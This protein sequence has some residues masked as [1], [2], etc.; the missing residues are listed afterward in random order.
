[1]HP[2]HLPSSKVSFPALTDVVVVLDGCFALPF[3]VVREGPSVVV[4]AV[5]LLPFLIISNEVDALAVPFLGAVEDEDM[6]LSLA[7]QD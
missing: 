6:R 5:T 2:A 1:M 3:F 4:V 7:A